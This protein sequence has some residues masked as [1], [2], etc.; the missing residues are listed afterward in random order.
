MSCGSRQRDRPCCR[1][2]LPAL[3]SSSASINEADERCRRGATRRWPISRD[4]PDRKR[5]AEVK[6][7]LDVTVTNFS[8]RRRCGASAA[9][10]PGSLQR[11]RMWLL[12]LRGRPPRRRSGGKASR[13]SKSLRRATARLQAPHDMAMRTLDR[14]VLVRTRGC[15]GWA[16]CVWRMSPGCARQ[17]LLGV[18]VEVAKC[19]RQAV[20]TCSAAPRGPQRI[21]QA[22]GQTTKLRRDTTWACTKPEQASG[23]DRADAPAPRR[24]SRCRGASCR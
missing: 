12:A 10:K 13:S 23:S 24:Q 19:R 8:R 7:P 17:I 11:Y 15:C 20:A 22:L 5:G 3:A 14:S 1:D 4:G 18:A 9:G 6:P 2:R 16:S 21:L